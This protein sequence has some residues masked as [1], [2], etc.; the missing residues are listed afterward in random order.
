M[1]LNVMNAIHHAIWLFHKKNIEM[2]ILCNI[3][4]AFVINIEFIIKI[5]N[6]LGWFQFMHLHFLN[7]HY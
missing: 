6:Y 1:D 2:E 5:E 4:T 3:I 7:E